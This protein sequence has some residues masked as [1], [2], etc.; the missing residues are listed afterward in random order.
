MFEICDLVDCLNDLISGLGQVG[1]IIVIVTNLLIYIITIIRN[2]FSEF[3]FSKDTY[4]VYMGAKF[5]RDRCVFNADYVE[6][7]ITDL[8]I[9]LQSGR[10][11]S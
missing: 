1:G 10:T 3:R 4:S 2:Y 11:C 7:F 9:T 8:I 6:T 5:V